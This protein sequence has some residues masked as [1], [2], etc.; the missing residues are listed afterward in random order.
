MTLIFLL[1][2]LFS[3]TTTNLALATPNTLKNYLAGQNVDRKWLQ[4]NL[5]ASQLP[6]GTLRSLET[7]ELRLLR[8]TLY[9]L[10]GARFRSPALRRFFSKQSWY[11]GYV[12]SRKV[13][14]PTK[15]KRQLKEFLKAEQIRKHFG[16]LLGSW[17][18]SVR[19]RGA[20]TSCLLFP[21]YAVYQSTRWVVVQPRKRGCQTRRKARL[22]RRRTSAAE[23]PSFYGLLGHFLVLRSIGASDL[24]TIEL[25]DLR[26]QKTRLKRVDIPGYASFSFDPKRKLFVFDQELRFPKAC[27]RKGQSYAARERTCWPLL[28]TQHPILKSLAAPQCSCKGGLGPGIV[29]KYT[30]SLRKPGQAPK[31]TQALTC[32]CSS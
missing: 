23:G 16:A 28:Q 24:Q 12:A 22:K 31:M 29:V 7:Y 18:T 2:L 10:Q 9:A 27:Q 3:L 30:L 11:K 21:H 13:K 25:V 5:V 15:A 19:S 4:Q 14:L 17:P 20:K 1:S 6:L 8:N 32:G 26:T